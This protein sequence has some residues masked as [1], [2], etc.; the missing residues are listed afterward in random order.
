MIPLVQE[1]FLWAQ[2]KVSLQILQYGN[3]LQ[4]ARTTVCPY[5]RCL[6]NFTYIGVLKWLGSDLH[7]TCEWVKLGRHVR[8]FATPWTIAYQAP[9]SMAF[10]RQ[11][12][13]MGCHYLHQGIFLTWGW[14]LDLLHCGQTFYPLSHHGSPRSNYKAKTSSLYTEDI[15]FDPWNGTQVSRIVDRSFSIWATRK[16]AL[17]SSNK[18]IR[19]EISPEYSLEG[20]MLQLKLQ[21]FGYLLQRTDSLEKTLMLGK[22]E[23]RKR[24][25]WQRMRWL[26]GIT[27]SIDMSLS[28]LWE[29]VMDREAWRAAFQGVAKSQTWLSDWTEKCLI[30]YFSL[31]SVL[32]INYQM[33]LN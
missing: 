30:K 3:R 22:I 10:S 31:L 24:R 18:S 5:N 2:N 28:K 6:E 19:K 25:G 20:L 33:P 16:M 27:D 4:F 21:Y 23:G 1:N 13:G 29:L 17:V 9:P 32:S 14:N 26:D 8:L 7:I 15:C 11:N 12:T